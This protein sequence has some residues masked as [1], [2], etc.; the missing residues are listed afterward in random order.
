MRPSVVEPLYTQQR[1]TVANTKEQRATDCRFG[2]SVENTLMYG[3]N[4][5]IE[6]GCNSGIFCHCGLHEMFPT[7][8]SKQRSVAR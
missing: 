1:R 3:S 6:M 2:R 8:R 4:R 7:D 5:I